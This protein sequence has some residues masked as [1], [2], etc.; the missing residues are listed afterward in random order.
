MNFQEKVFEIAEGFRNRADAVV[1]VA[2]SAAR[3]QAAK[4][5]DTLK[6]TMTALQVAGREFGAVARRHGARF[7]KENATL[8]RAAGQ[9][10]SALVSSTYSQFSKREATPVRKRRK[11]S[12]TRKRAAAKAA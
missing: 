11:S 4:R 7:V 8:A 9:D 1:Q 5:A 10:V 3:T 6:T 2:L 12:A